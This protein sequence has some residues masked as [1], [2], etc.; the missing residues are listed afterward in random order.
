[1]STK[2]LQI[3]GSLGTDI[4]LDS[5]LLESGKAADAKAVGD[6]LAQKQPV[7]DYA[8]ETYVNNA[9]STIPTPDVSGQIGSHNTSTSAHSD[10]RT[11]LNKKADDYSIEIYNGTS[12]NPKPVRFMTVNYSTC[13]SENGVAIKLGMVSGHGNG[14]S[15]AFLQDA[16]IKV[17]HTGTV[18]VDN[19]KYY[20][21]ATTLDGNRQ[22]GDIFWTIDTTNT[23]VDF[24]C[25]MGQYARIQMTPWKRVTYSTGGTIT[26]YTSCTVYSSGDKVWGNNSDI[27]LMSDIISIVGD[28]NSILDAINGEVV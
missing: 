14:T 26:Q 16:I 25:L 17:G 27:A 2:K 12:G 1:M 4:E 7:G 8:T 24:Y 19:F 15:Y 28:I 20:G 23:V 6:A 21:A 11:Q 18:E 22:Y 5:T 10:I 3:L 13:G 9:I